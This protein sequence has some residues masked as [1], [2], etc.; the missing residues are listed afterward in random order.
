[1]SLTAYAD[2]RST[3]VTQ[4]T[5]DLTAAGWSIYGSP[6]DAFDAPAVLI[7]AQ[8]ADRINVALWRRDLVV[9]LFVRRDSVDASYDLI[10][11][12]IPALVTS[13]ES[14][15]GVTIGTVSRPEPVTWT[16]VPYMACFVPVTMETTP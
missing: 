7:A 10:D 16:D 5:T 4:L 3:L 12:T 15:D 13:L 2:A 8:E 9:G 14:V 6:P 11:A 1:M